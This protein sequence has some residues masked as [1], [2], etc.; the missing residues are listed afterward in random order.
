[1]TIIKFIKD[2]LGEFLLLSVI[3]GMIIL[4]IPSLRR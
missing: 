4:I 3:V 2:A 1:M